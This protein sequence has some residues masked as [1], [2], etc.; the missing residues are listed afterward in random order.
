MI[1]HDI[2][3]FILHYTIKFK[4]ILNYNEKG[5]LIFKIFLIETQTKVYRIVNNIFLIDS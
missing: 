1:I 3:Y 4:I 2:I 5:E